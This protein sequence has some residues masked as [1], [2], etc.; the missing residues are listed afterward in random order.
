MASTSSKLALLVLVALLSLA[1]ASKKVDTLSYDFLVFPK[2]CIKTFMAGDV[3]NEFCL[4]KTISKVLGYGII[5]GACIVK[6]PQILRFVAAGSVAGVS[7]PATYL[8]LLGYLLGSIY[9]IVKGNP[10]SAYGE[11]VIVTVQSALIVLML[12]AYD[13]PGVVHMATVTGVLATVGQAAW[14]APDAMQEI[15]MSSTTVL[16]ILSRG[17]QIVENVQAGSTGQLA[18]LTLFMNFAGAAARIFTTL[19]EVKQKAVLY[20]FIISTSLNA[21]LLAQ[22]VYYNWLAPSAKGGKKTAAVPKPKAAEAAF[23]ADESDASAPSSASKG[24][25]RRRRQA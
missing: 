16:F 2:G 10:W 1:V 15:V 13:A 23:L 6:V 5:A 18:F 17:W 12:W 11:T 19:Q 21:L 14:S 20:S 24:A 25:T 7:R 9:H 3:L 22:Y 8:E 4:K